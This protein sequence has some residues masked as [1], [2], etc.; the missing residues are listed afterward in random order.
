MGTEYVGTMRMESGYTLENVRVKVD[1]DGTITLYRVKF[2]RMM[3]VRVD[4]VIPNVRYQDQLLCAEQSIPM[5]DDK[6]H[7]D[8]MI[9]ALRGTADDRAID[10][11]CLFGGKEMHYQGQSLP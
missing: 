9:T 7:P 11:R 2:A 6:Q 1:S 5:V 10:F 4:V 3:P 8:R